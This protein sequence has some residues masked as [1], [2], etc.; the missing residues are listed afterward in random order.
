MASASSSRG[1]RIMDRV[2]EEERKRS[3]TTPWT[4]LA[5]DGE[6]DSSSSSAAAMA[7]ARARAPAPRECDVYV[8]HGRDARRLAAWL[9]AELE[10]LG[11]PCVASNRRQCGDAPAHAAATG[12][13]DG[14]LVGVVLVTPASLSN[15]YAVEEVCH[16]LDRGALVPVFAGGVR[17]SDL[18]AGADVAV[19]RRGGELWEK[20]GGRLWMAYDGEEQQWRQAVEG[21]AGSEPAVEVR[22]GDLRDRVLDVVELVGA[23]LGRRAVGPTVRAWRAE[24]ELKIPFPW[25]EGFV[26]REKELLDV[27][28]MLRG[29][30]AHH[31]AL[32]D[33][34]KAS[35]KR[36]MY[37]DVVN[38]GAFLDG[39]VCITG[40]SGAGKTELAL[41][42]VHRHCHQYKKVLWVHGEARYL[43]QSFLKLADHLGIAVGDTIFFQSKARSTTTTTT[44]NLHDIEGDAIA[45]I[46]KELTR[47]IPYLLVIDNLESETDWWDRRAI[48]ELLP[49]GCKRTRIIITTKLAGGVHGVRTLSLGSLDA[50]NAM[51]LMKGARTFGMEDTAI[52]RDIQKTVG[53]VTLGF[54]LVGGVL[55]ELPV[56]GPGELRRAMRHAPHRSPVWET[57][58]DAALRDNPGLV[59]L[60]D[61]CFALLRREE[62]GSPAARGRLAAAAERVVEAS[63]YFAPVPVSSAMLV[64]AAAAAAGAV[65]SSSSWK[66]RWFKRTMRLSCASP[67]PTI[68]GGRAEHQAA[69]AMLLRLGIARRSTHHGCVSV[70]GV[71]RLFARKVGGG[72]GARAAVDTIASGHGAVAAENTDFHKVAACLSLFFK[73][74]SSAMAVKLPEPELARFVTGAVIPL[75]ARYVVGHSAYG[76]ALEILREATDAVFAAEERYTTTDDGGSSRRRRG[77]AGDGGGHVERLDPKVYRELARARAELL[78]M[79]A[80][81]MMRAGERDIAEDHCVSAVSILEVVNGDWHPDTVAILAPAMNGSESITVV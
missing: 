3:T 12:A 41:E 27:D 17:R 35:G 6:E 55:A 43:R 68:T 79:R 81:V 42:F 30:A 67:L 53:D 40:S 70:H 76:A 14:A 74:E 13:M 64:D 2:E 22:G 4:F 58:D 28:A 59:Q 48:T 34:D 31:R 20:N 78:V 1:I 10:M 45:K 5:V 71:F 52:L 9:R 63:S 44:R 18:A 66:K 36:P 15:P 62:E 19:E 11:I 69:L 46:K 37:L 16:F 50:S 24:A 21:L 60:L 61:A 73:F 54:A 25:N 38:N 75:A 77:V 49:R 33:N 32:L 56:V 26:G 80:R 57:K 47:D 8:G 39:V 23:R 65:T 29:G 51:R 72:S 7:R